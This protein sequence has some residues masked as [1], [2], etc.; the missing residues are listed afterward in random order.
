MKNS[1]ILLVGLV[2]VSCNTSTP[3]PKEKK[4]EEKQ[5][6]TTTSEDL[7]DTAKI[8]S[9][10]TFYLE[11]GEVTSDYKEFKYEEKK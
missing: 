8:I 5:K 6:E 4:S 9:I 11:E 7:A 1:M 10:D 3:E 2:L